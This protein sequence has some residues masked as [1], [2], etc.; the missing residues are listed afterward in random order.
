MVVRVVIRKGTYRDSVTLMK[1][2]NNV[3]E[4]NGVLQAAV[5]MA[6]PTNKQLLK[7]VRL[8]TDEIE[9]AGPNDLVIAL[10]TE[11]DESMKIALSEVDRL[12]SARE[13][14]EVEQ[15]LP[16]TLDS[17]LSTMPDANLVMISVP[18]IFAK[19]EALR[20][21]RR[22]LNVFLFSSNVPIEEEVELKKISKD[23]GL[24]MMGPDCGTALIN[25]I[26]LGFGNAVSVGSI[27]VVS[28]SGTGL[29]QVSTLIQREGLGISQ[30]IG[31]GGNDL[32]KKVGGIMMIEG[33]KLLDKDEKTQAIVL[34]SKPP[35]PQIREKILREASRCT[36]PVVVNFLGGEIDEIK[37]WGCYA[38]TTLEDAARIVCALVKGKK[39]E[40][41]IF[42][43]PERRIQST[44]KAESSKLSSMQK[45][46]RGLFSGGS[47]CYET[48]VILAPIIGDI[49]SNVPLKPWYKLEDVN[50]SKKHT[51]IDMGSEEFTIGRLHPMIDFTLRKRRIVQE[52]KDPETAVVLL[53]VVLGYG[54]HQ[55]PSAELVPSIAEAKTLAEHNGRFLSLV[56][57]IVGTPEDAQDM[58]KQEGELEGA[59]VIIMPSNA[60]AAR[61]AA[62]IA[63]RGGA[64]ERLFGGRG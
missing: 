5:V 3:A 17:A 56:A 49:Y 53:D 51:C 64:E 30:A 1:I 32:S 8:L 25:N 37:K 27:G 24:L 43:I 12:L 9:R 59:G 13:A 34:I 14:I 61:I 6:T 20:A 54:A 35:D 2:S 4:L 26:A 40:K 28:A 22:G 45:Y 55:N 44:F 19:R 31:T 41:T 16:K 11:S 21:L 7:D 29:Q 47:L 57:S 58:R 50:V 63:T 15:V 23:S 38:A 39:H 48:Q 10:D 62:L 60:Q 52:A 33:I 18:G 36:K 42:T 46:V